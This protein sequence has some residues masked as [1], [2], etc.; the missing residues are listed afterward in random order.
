MCHD[1][2]RDLHDVDSHY[3]FAEFLPP[4]ILPQEEKKLVRQHLS[5]CQKVIFRIHSLRTDDLTQMIDR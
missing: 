1:P 4:F 2:D 3:I 5:I